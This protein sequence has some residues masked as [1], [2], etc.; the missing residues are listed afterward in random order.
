MRKMIRIPERRRR[1][2]SGA[3][4]GWAVVAAFVAGLAACTWLGGGLPPAPAAAQDARVIEWH[5]G[6]ST[7]AVLFLHGLGGCAVPSGANAQDWCASGADDSFRNPATGA[8]W[9]RILASDDSL[10]ARNALRAVLPEPF[11]ASDLGVWGVDYSHL[12]GAGCP[13]FSIEALARAVRLAIQASELYHRHEQVI[14]V[15]HSLGGL[16]AKEV[17][18]GWQL[19]DDP[20]NAYQARTIAVL[21]LGVPSQGSPFAPQPGL[22]RYFLETIGAGRLGGVCER[23]VKDLF[24]G[25]ENTYLAGLE[26]RWEA[27]IRAR[28]SRSQSQAPITGCAHETEAERVLPGFRTVIVPAL[29]S[30]TQCLL[31]NFEIGLTHTQLPKPADAGAAAH[32]RWLRDGLDQI[33]SDWSRWTFSAVSFTPVDPTLTA[34]QRRV[35]E[36]QGA[37]RLELDAGV[38]G[39]EPRAASYQAASQFGLVA[40]IVRDN[41]ELCLDARWP[42]RAAGVLTIRRSGDCP[43]PNNDSGALNEGAGGGQPRPR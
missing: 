3:L 28:R 31:G 21:L 19:A 36:V 9:P 40:R 27:L 24:V 29:Y 37:F 25:D 33:F 26:R 16:L 12:T 11:R 4:R 30:A 23:Q 1:G 18:L 43:S 22:W 39:F 13:R 2:Q 20:D 32:G 42:E 14:I 41:P 5:R 7:V 15:A 35:N 10:V 17:M 38:R 6:R 34:L 8:T